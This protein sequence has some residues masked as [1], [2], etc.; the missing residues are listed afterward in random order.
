MIDINN[1]I[2]EILP[3][4]K[5]TKTASRIA[6]K[7]LKLVSNETK[8]IPQVSGVDLGGSYAKGTWLANSADI[9]VFIKFYKDTPKTTFTKIFKKIGYTALREFNPYEKYAEH[10]YVIAEVD[11]V[12][13]NVVPCYDVKKGEWQSATDRSPYH[14]KHM[15]RYLT[16]LQKNEV[17]VLKKFLKNY[18]IYGA[19]IASQGFSGYVTEVLILNFG[20]FLKVIQ[21]IANIKNNEIIGQKSRDF[22]T[23]ITIT[24]PVDNNRNL[25]AAIS[26]RNI[27]L[28]ILACRT[29]LKSPSRKIFENKPGKSR[30]HWENVMCIEF[31]YTNRV[32][33][34]LWGQTK[35][36]LSALNRQLKLHGFVVIRDHIVISKERI[37]I[38]LFL[39]SFCISK[40]SIRQGPNVFLKDAVSRFIAKNTNNIIWVSNDMTLLCLDEREYASIF[41]ILDYLLSNPS[42]AG[43]PNGLHDDVKTYTLTGGEQ[44]NDL[45]KQKAA[46]IMSDDGAAVSST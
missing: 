18:N 32:L 12:V 42:V 27:A 10:P 9:D 1:L 20:G 35:K 29:F 30:E 24:D 19:E 36:A 28:F 13:I 21:N 31:S 3:T 25:A 22:D 17:R 14:T 37:H 26:K 8:N 4:E 34:V 45:I 7:V 2:Q 6:D 39:E 38:F 15:K 5:E 33:D 40:I 23:V 16:T 46:P 43:I 11:N 41:S 44:F